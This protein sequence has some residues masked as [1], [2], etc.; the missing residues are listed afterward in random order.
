M[1]KGYGD[2]EGR[3]LARRRLVHAEEAVRLADMLAVAARRAGFSDIEINKIATAFRVRHAELRQASEGTIEPRTPM[4]NAAHPLLENRKLNCLYLD[5][6]GTS[7][8]NGNDKVFCLGGVALHE[9]DIDSYITK[10]DELKLQ[11]F[12]T[13]DVTFHEPHMRR[14]KGFFSFGDDRDRQREFDAELRSL[15]QSTP[16]TLFA[17]AIRKQAFVT[18]FVLPGHDPY[19]PANVYDLAI[20]LL[21]ER[22]VDFLANH[23]DRRM[24]RV[25]LESIGK[26][27]DAEHQAAYS[28][29]MLHGTQF[30]NEKAFQSWVETGCRF[31]PKSGSSPAELADLVA[32]DAFE[33]VASDCSITPPF[34]DI[35]KMKTYIRADGKFGRFGLKVFPSTGLDQ[36]VDVHR[37]DCGG[38]Q[39]N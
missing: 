4:K 17:V 9:S 35:L 29:L 31:G 34:W 19:L 37:I 38:T 11:F 33:W 16:F 36:L 30:V 8:L 13:V 28:D 27:D 10:A 6:S 24:G 39:K 12:G 32:R 25:H 26:R 23:A 15:V 1:S 2:P 7:S 21:M 20:M 3:K 22:Y 18:E 5:E 14:R